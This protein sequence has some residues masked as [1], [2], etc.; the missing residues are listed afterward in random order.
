ML[1][2]LQHEIHGQKTGKIND[3][4]ICDDCAEFEGLEI[5]VFG[6]L[7]GSCSSGPDI[8][9]ASDPA[10]EKFRSKEED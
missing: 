9:V 7:S 1:V 3:P 4:H 6:K 8:P 5:T 2:L 10:C